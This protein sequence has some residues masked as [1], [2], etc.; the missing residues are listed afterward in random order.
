MGIFTQFVDR[1]EKEEIKA[2]YDDDLEGYLESLDLWKPI[3]EGI[4]DCHFCK[5]SVSRDSIGAI[6]PTDDGIAV[7]CDDESCVYQATVWR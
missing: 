5:T 2:V 1:P 7:V 3:K 6:V 4:V